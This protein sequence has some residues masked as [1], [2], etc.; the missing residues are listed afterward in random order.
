MTRRVAGPLNR[1]AGRGQ[2]GFVGFGGDEI[3]QRGGGRVSSSDLGLS[4]G[5]RMGALGGPK[6]TPCRQKVVLL[7]RP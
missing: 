2:P 7:R 4:Y 6:G 3:E 1:A 5:G